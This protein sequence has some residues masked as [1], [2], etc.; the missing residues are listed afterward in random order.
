[1]LSI[2][3]LAVTAALNTVKN[4]IPNVTHLVKKIEYDVKISDIEAKYFT[5][6]DNNKFADKIVD[7]KIK[8]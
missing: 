4:K 5:T 6:S 1:M 7:T 8:E 3:G 2:T